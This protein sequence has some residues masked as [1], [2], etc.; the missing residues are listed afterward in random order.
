MIQITSPAAASRKWLRISGARITLP[1]SRCCR[2]PPRI[3]QIPSSTKPPPAVSNHA[4]SA[5]HFIA[6]PLRSQMTGLRPLVCIYSMDSD[7]T[8][9]A[10]IMTTRCLGDDSGFRPEQPLDEPFP[11]TVIELP[12]ASVCA[13]DRP[14]R[15]GRRRDQPLLLVRLDNDRVKAGAT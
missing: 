13:H 5:A 2:I 15:T 1:A 4:I 9:F 12:P 11:E 14:Q 3:N 6:S 8:R 7:E 10:V